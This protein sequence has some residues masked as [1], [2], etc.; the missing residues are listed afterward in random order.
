MSKNIF[1]LHGN[2][3]IGKKIIYEKNDFTLF[4]DP[5]ALFFVPGNLFSWWRPVRYKAIHLLKKMQ[6]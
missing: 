5:R 3:A 6:Q 2:E 4:A 1:L